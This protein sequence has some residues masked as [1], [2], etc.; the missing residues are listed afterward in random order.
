VPPMCGTRATFSTPAVVIHSN[1]ALA[2]PITLREV[3]STMSED[4]GT[5]TEGDVS[6]EQTPGT[7]PVDVIVALQ[8]KGLNG[9][10][11]HAQ[12]RKAYK[13]V[14]GENLEMKD[15]PDLRQRLGGVVEKEKPAAKPKAVKEEKEPKEKKELAKKEPKAKPTAEQAL[16]KQLALNPDRWRKVVRVT[17]QGDEGNITRVVIKCQNPQKIGDVEICKGEREIAVQ[18]LFQVNNCQPCQRRLNSIKRNDR[19]KDKRKERREEA[20]KLN[21]KVAEP[22]TT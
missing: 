15:L 2:A 12:I 4:T 20:E 6:T 11:P 22:A 10:S 19:T 9:N 3:L 14:T 1:F 18:D 17:E 7:E 16:A 21:A 8:A 13:E 5:T